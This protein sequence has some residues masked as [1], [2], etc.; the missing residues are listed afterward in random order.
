MFGPLTTAINALL[1]LCV[2]AAPW[3]TRRGFGVWGYWGRSALGIG[4]AVALAEGGKRWQVWP[5][6]P[7]FPS[8]HETLCLAAATCLAARDPRWLRLGLPLSALQA[9][10]LVRGGFHAPVEVA[11]ALLSGP[12]VALLC[13]MWGR[14]G[15]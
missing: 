12:P 13:Q 4:L 10:A 8:G 2:A 1:V 14:R 15:G 11:G 5:G 9:W 7:G 6:H 3:I